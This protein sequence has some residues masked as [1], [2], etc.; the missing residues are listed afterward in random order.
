MVAIAPAIIVVPL[1]K[2]Y[3]IDRSES[4]M[5][6][7]YSIH[8]LRILHPKNLLTKILHPPIVDTLLQSAA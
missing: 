1:P 7:C 5:T 2:E 3:G 8:T 6:C 4:E